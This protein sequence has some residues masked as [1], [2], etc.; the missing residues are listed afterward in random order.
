MHSRPHDMV[1]SFGVQPTGDAHAPRMSHR[2]RALTYVDK[3][4]KR[5]AQKV[6]L[7]LWHDTEERCLKEGADTHCDN[8]MTTHQILLV[9]GHSPLKHLAQLSSCEAMQTQNK[10]W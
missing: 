4:E 6:V 8:A 10:S 1:K 7:T 2:A 5:Q 3:A 9:I